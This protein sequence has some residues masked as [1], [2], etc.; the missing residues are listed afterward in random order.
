ML[1]LQ[2]VAICDNDTTNMGGRYLNSFG[3]TDP[4]VEC[5]HCLRTICQDNTWMIIHITSIL[6]VRRLW[7]MFFDG[8]SLDD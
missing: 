8:W 1:I 4:F 5:K 3:H 2:L 7:L 6:G